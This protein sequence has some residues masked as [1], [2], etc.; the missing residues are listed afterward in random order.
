MLKN[1]LLEQFKA[2]FNETTWF[3]CFNMILNVEKPYA[4][5]PHAVM[6]AEPLSSLLFND[7][8]FGE[9]Q[10]KRSCSGRKEDAFIPT[11]TLY[12]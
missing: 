12:H 10:F 3:V 7:K 1:I 9:R 6:G 8:A 4:E 5:Q 11:V 2:C